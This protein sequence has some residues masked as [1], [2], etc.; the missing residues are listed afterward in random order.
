[1]CQIFYLFICTD[2]VSQFGTSMYVRGERARSETPFI[3]RIY[4]NNF[5]EKVYKKT[6]IYINILDKN[7]IFGRVYE[8]ILWYMISY[9]KFSLINFLK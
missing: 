4:F 7:Y 1:M 9:F 5:F 6:L 8:N 2:D 3:N